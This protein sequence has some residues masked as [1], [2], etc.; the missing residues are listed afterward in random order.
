MVEC[1]CGL[2]G[3]VM[4]CILTGL[5]AYLL[6]GRYSQGGVAVHRLMGWNIDS[7]AEE[8]TLVV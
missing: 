3:I 6:W 7:Q 4:V 2:K 5:M 8:V 1:L